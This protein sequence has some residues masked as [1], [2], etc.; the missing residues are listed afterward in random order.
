M[1]ELLHETILLIV[2]VQKDC[3]C[4]VNSYHMTLYDFY[5]GE[6]LL[7]HAGAIY[8]Y[9]IFHVCFCW[10]CHTATFFW[11]IMFPFHARA[12]KRQGIF[13]FLYIA[14]LVASLILPTAPVI[15]AF[16]TGEGFVVRYF[17]PLLCVAQSAVLHYTL[18]IP[19]SV[20]IGLV[21]SFLILIIAELIKVY[22]Y[23]NL[24]AAFA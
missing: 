9:S 19:V 22:K 12:C 8:Y 24:H 6:L 2:L 4:S 3:D 7:I 1:H 14:V 21:T 23:Y 18:V 16:S 13:K 10:F 20:M 5:I 17:P 11:Q 15:A